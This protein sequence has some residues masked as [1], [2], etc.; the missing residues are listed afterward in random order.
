[1]HR[2]TV[3]ASWLVASASLLWSGAAAAQE[4]GRAPGGADSGAS[5]S[6]TYRLRPGDTMDLLF[7]FATSFNQ[8]VAVRP[9]GFI[10]LRAVGDVRAEG[11]T[12]PE[13][14]ELLRNSYSSVLQQP[15]LTI[16]L[17]DFERRYFVAA[18]EVARPGK[19][20]M[21]GETRLTQALAI[22][23]GFTDRAKRTEVVVFRQTDGEAEAVGILEVNASDLLDGRGIDKDLQ[24][25]SG[26]LVFVSRKRMPSLGTLSITLLPTLGWLAAAFIR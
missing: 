3:I 13:L 21:R 20:D 15:V 7:P 23:G 19:Y 16:E 6:S 4:S 22:A 2:T 14:A 10:G 18:G 5:A 12:V 11:R 25:E 8:T 9:D 24:L 17:R 1:M 26:D